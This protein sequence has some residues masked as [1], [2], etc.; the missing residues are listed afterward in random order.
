MGVRGEVSS[1]ASL[2]STEQEEDDPSVSKA[3]YLLSGILVTM[4]REERRRPHTMSSRECIP[5]Y[6]RQAQTRRVLDL[7]RISDT[8]NEFNYFTYSPMTTVS[9]Q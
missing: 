5:R 4:I 9:S 6:N 7:G 3:K 8:R 1:V 2:P